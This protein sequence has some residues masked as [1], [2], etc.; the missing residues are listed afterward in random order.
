[1]PPQQSAQP[2]PVPQL[3]PAQRRLQQTVPQLQPSRQHSPLPRPLPPPQQSLRPLQQRHQRPVRP[4][5]TLLPSQPRPPEQQP[6]PPQLHASPPPPSQQHHTVH[7]A[8]Q[9]K[10]V[11]FH[12]RSQQEMHNLGDTRCSGVLPP[13]PPKLA[14]EAALLASMLSGADW[15]MAAPT[16]SELEDLRA[17]LGLDPFGHWF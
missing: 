15:E 12:V 7:P 10:P 14:D 5:F 8:A 13:G 16:E 3:R 2:E 17:E 6:A 1:M 11:K 4:C 9:R